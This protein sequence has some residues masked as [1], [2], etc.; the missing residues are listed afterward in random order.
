MLI[1]GE[2]IN[3]KIYEAPKISF[4]QNRLDEEYTEIKDVNFDKHINSTSSETCILRGYH[5]FSYHLYNQFEKQK[6]IDVTEGK[7]KDCGLQFYKL[8][9]KKK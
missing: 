1:E 2:F 6:K 4:A 8:K 5:I 9:S 7:C 3:N